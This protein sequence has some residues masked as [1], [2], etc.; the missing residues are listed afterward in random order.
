M[1]KKDWMPKVKKIPSRFRNPIGKFRIM[2]ESTCT[3]CGK[4][5]ELCPEGVHRKAGTKMAQPKD[6]YC[7]GFKCQENSFYCIDKCPVKALRL[8]QNPI[9]ETLGDYRWTSDLLISTW[10]QAETG[11]VP[12]ADVEYNVGNSQG[13][14]DKLRF[15]FP[16]LQAD[17]LI[18]EDEISTAI[19]LNKRKD[20]K[21]PITIPI[22]IYG[23]GMSFGSVSVATMLA[24]A[25]AAKAWQTFTCTGEG[26]YPEILAPFDD[27]M[28]TENRQFKESELWSLNMPKEQSP[29]SVAIFW[30]TKIPH[31]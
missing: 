15:R 25:Q 5:S 16:E 6:Y 27:Y 28:I 13:G 24:R 19:D 18:P 21:P 7:L 11:E 1:S 9:C 14:F 22:P 23:G 4:C 31:L 3:A 12:R 29:V 20:G 17:E 30:G 2:R 26:G 8:V 10:M